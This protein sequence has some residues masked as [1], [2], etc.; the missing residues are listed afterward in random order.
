MLTPTAG[1]DVEAA[2]L[3][4]AALADVAA[5]RD[6]AIGAS[7]PRRGTAGAGAGLREAHDAATIAG[8][9][10]DRG[11]VLLYRDT[12]AYRY[13]IDLLEDGGPR[14]HLRAAV[15]RVAAYDAERRARLLPTLDEYLAQGRSVAATA[16]ALTIHVNTLRQRLERIETL[17]GL[18]LADEDLLALQ[19]AVKLARVRA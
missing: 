8:V 10:I 9:L 16:R 6:L 3:V 18:A 17:T 5:E 11:D 2:R 1:D 7:E 4:T 14:D 19:L 15:E 12:G 13:L